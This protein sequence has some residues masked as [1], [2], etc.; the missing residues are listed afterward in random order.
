MRLMN[1]DGERFKMVRISWLV[2]EEIARRGVFGET[3]DMVLRRV[4]ELP[5]DDFRVKH[6]RRKKRQHDG[7]TVNAGAAADGRDQHP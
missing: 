6:D 7:G 1:K 5:L 4:F 3:V 2:Y